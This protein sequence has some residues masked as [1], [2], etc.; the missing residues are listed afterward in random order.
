MGANTVSGKET[1]YKD[2]RPQQTIAMNSFCIMRDNIPQSLATDL[3]KQFGPALGPD[4][5]DGPD[6][7]TWRGA[8]QLAEALTK[9]IG[10]V[11][12]LPTEAEW[13]FAARGGL[14]NKEFPWGNAGDMYDGKLVRD[15][16]LAGRLECR[17]YSVQKMLVDEAIKKCVPKNADDYMIFKE[18]GCVEKLLRSRV[19]NPVSNSYGLVNIVNNEWEWTSSRY[20]PYPYRANDGRE[21]TTM[22]N[23]DFRVIR[24]GNNN[25]ET[26]LGY[27][28][29]RGFG[30]AN[31][32]Q[33]SRY[34]V[35]FVLEN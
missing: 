13:E 26:C 19:P 35:R 29:L 20:M 7:M 9:Q 14:V 25:S 32:E 12:R 15:I 22:G 18:S 2:E 24:G 4:E 1:G 16:V 17:L 31:K 33:E 28:S 8:R 21:T 5:A 23:R 11:V 27:T 6:L 3:R 10:K 30:G 34:K